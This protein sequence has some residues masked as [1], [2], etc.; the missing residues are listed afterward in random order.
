M[1]FNLSP[2]ATLDQIR[3]TPSR[4]DGIPQLL[5]D[6]LRMYGAQL[7]QEAGRLSK[8]CVSK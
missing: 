3:L 8:L 6:D 1:S 2:L 5:E 7:I 4:E